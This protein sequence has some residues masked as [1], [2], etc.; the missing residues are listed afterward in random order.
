MKKSLL[1]SLK[2][3]KSKELFKRTLLN[4]Y[5]EM[6]KGALNYSLTPIQYFLY[7]KPCYQMFFKYFINDDHSIFVLMSE[8]IL[9]Y[10][11]T[12]VDLFIFEINLIMNRFYRI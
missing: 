10:S 3:S 8:G 12:C 2:K 4:K 6:Q 1:S 11:S 7:M 9:T 5:V